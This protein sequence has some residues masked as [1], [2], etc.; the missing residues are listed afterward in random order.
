[1]VRH[2]ARNS[3]NLGFALIEILVVVAIIAILSAITYSVY[4]GHSKSAPPGKAHTPTER[5]KDVV[6]MQDL[7]SV[8]QSIEAF[9]ASDVDAKYPQS[10]TE[11]KEL[12]AEVRECPEGKEPYTYDPSSGAVHCTH[13]GHENY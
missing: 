9:R 11:M 8:R 7:R 3:R 6:C 12:P 1:M 13:P 5:A 2:S 4:V 10:L